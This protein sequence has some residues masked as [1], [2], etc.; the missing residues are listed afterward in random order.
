M[1]DRFRQW[2]A[3]PR[4]RPHSWLSPA[5]QVGAANEPLNA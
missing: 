1:R 3:P 5:E 4:P 2:P